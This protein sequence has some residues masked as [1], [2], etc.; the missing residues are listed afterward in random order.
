MFKVITPK[1]K[2]EIEEYYKLRWSLLRRPLGGKRGSEID[3][4]ERT[5]FHRAIVRDKIIVGVGRIHFIDNIAQI[6]YMAVKNNFSRQGLGSKMITE[7]EKL[8]EEN[9]I[10]KIY[11]NSRINAV[12]FYEN[13]GYSKIRKT[14]SSFGSI[15]HYR[16]EKILE[17]L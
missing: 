11:L 4:L 3:K 8:A 15:V 2:K 14:K 17:K 13:N 1:A 5:S 9:K 6:R 12:K 10:K 16:M 7:L